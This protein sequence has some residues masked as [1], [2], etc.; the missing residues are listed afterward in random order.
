MTETTME[1]TQDTSLPSDAVPAPRR[2]SAPVSHP[3]RAE[4]AARGRQP[5]RRHR[6]SRTRSSRRARRGRTRWTCCSGRP[7]R[8]SPSWSRSGTAGCWCRR[9]PSTGAAA[10]PMAADLATTATAGPGCPAVRRRAPEQ[11]RRLRVAGTPA[12]V[13]PQR[14]RR[15]AARSLRVG[16]EAARCQLRGRHPGQRFQ[17]Q[18]AA[19]DR[20]DSRRRRTARR[21]GSSPGSRPLPSGTPGWTS[22]PTS[23]ASART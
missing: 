15:D 21:C 10:L 3:T 19:E 12:G 1:E 11:L 9:S 8:G 14:L 6:W 18:G 16:R 17:R 23:P 4:R 20:R 7:S 22:S 13:R 5:G 2:R